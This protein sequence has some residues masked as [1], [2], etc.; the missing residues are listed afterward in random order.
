MV[1]FYMVR[2]DYPF[3]LS[4]GEI[5]MIVTEA[6]CNNLRTKPS[7]FYRSSF[8]VYVFEIFKPSFRSTWGEEQL[9]C[10]AIQSLV[11][12]SHRTECD[13]KLLVIAGGQLQVTWNDTRHDRRVFLYLLSLC[14]PNIIKNSTIVKCNYV[15]R[16]KQSLCKLN[17][18]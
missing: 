18:E 2:L 9:G 13:V 5:M 8:F 7:N 11:R 12:L 3:A 1:G 17:F 10:L 16:S 4:Y 14:T 6:M 15:G